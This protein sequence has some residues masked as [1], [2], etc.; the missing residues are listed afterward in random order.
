MRL[1][2]CLLFVGRVL[3]V[4]GQEL[5]DFLGAFLL[6]NFGKYLLILL[7][8]IV[9][10]RFEHVHVRV[11]EEVSEVSQT[12]AERRSVVGLDANINH[13]VLHEVTECFS[14]P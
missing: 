14:L 6:L 4:V 10:N 7:H 9:E 13:S 3:V 5:S 2:G 8:Q 11:L 1:E 12:V